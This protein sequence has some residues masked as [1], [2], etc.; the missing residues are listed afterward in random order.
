MDIKSILV[1]HALGIGEVCFVSCLGI[2]LHIAIGL[3][4][5][6]SLYGFKLQEKETVSFLMLRNPG[7]ISFC[8]AHFVLPQTG[9]HLPYQTEV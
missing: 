3:L 9:T 4:Q 6:N 2:L 5:N 1:L 8:L 7:S